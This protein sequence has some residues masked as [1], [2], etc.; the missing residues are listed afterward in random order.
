VQLYIEKSKLESNQE[1]AFAAVKNLIDVGDIVGASGSV[2]RTEKGEMSVNVAQ[3][4]VLTKSLLP[5][6]DK[7]HGLADVEKRYRWG[8]RGSTGNIASS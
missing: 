4:Q 6:P 3:L 7:W 2:K 8:V 5:L 1:G